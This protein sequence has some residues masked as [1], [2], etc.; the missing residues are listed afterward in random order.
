MKKLFLLLI[1]TSPV[2]LA[3]VPQ[4]SFSN[5]SIISQTVG[6]KLKRKP[7]SKTFDM[8]LDRIAKKESGPSA[9]DAPSSPDQCRSEALKIQFKCPA[10]WTMPKEEGTAL[11]L[12]ST[13]MAAAMYVAQIDTA[14][15]YLHQLDRTAMKK[16][17]HY[18]D[19]FAVEE[20]S[21]A[22]ENA[23]RV[24]AFSDGTPSSR[25]TDYYLIHNEKFYRISFSVT[26]K[27]LWDEHKFVI[28]ELSKAFSFF[29][30]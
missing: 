27:E 7:G 25:M 28:Q 13:D 29:D 3:V 18:A 10:N 6:Q 11:F 9:S 17:G 8:M 1:I 24:K 21:F 26:P 22:D 19:G 23:L 2:L 5:E 4:A 20:I 12:S 14:F 30:D 16:I 15:R